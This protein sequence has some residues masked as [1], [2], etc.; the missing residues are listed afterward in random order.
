VKNRATLQAAQIAFLKRFIWKAH[1]NK[2]P[3]T[4][5]GTILI[6]QIL[7]RFKIDARKRGLSPEQAMDIARPY[8]VKWATWYDFD[9]FVWNGRDAIKL[10]GP[11]ELGEA[12]GLTER[13]WFLIKPRRGNGGVIPFDKGRDPQVQEWIEAAKKKSADERKDKRKARRS[14]LRDGLETD[15]RKLLAQ[16]LTY[17]AIADRFQAELRERP[18]REGILFWTERHVFNFNPDRKN[19]EH[20]RQYEAELM[21]MKRQQAMTGRERKAA[22]IEK[23]RRMIH[24]MH[25]EGMGYGT[26]ARELNYR[27]IPSRAG[28]KWHRKSISR[29]LSSVDRCRQKCPESPA[30][31]TRG[32]TDREKA[33]RKSQAANAVTQQEGYIGRLHQA[34][35]ANDIS[36]PR[37][38][39]SEPSLI[40]MPYTVPLREL[41]SS[42]AMAA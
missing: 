8:I 21:R 41:Y 1:R 15:V 9:S 37:Q 26:I 16:G 36:M 38:S 34:N 33:A 27:E 13:L 17:H 12:I 35:H 29:E 14:E 25:A 39:W 19:P 3:K 42:M 7:L 2:I 6:E 32:T 30:T 10:L 5:Q 4:D 28:G 22:E 40:E 24:A 18:T 20:K 31:Y 11:Y 23:T